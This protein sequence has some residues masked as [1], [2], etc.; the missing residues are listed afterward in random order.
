MVHGIHAAGR[1]D[2][3]AALWQQFR[4][5]GTTARGVSFGCTKMSFSPRSAS[6]TAPPPTTS[7]AENVLGTVMTGSGS[8]STSTPWNVDGGSNR[9]T[10][11]TMLR[12]L[13]TMTA[14]ALA[15]SWTAPP[16]IA[17][18]ASGE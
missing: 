14:I 17:T 15:K 12:P 1:Q 11:S 6:V 4:R 5:P 18:T 3:R 8:T 13:G 7:A 9:L 10:K 16:P 2:C